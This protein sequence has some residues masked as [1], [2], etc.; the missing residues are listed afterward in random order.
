M[1]LPSGT[2]PAA[3]L[4]FL[5]NQLPLFLRDRLGV[6]LLMVAG[7]PGRSDFRLS[8]DDSVRRPRNLRTEAGRLLEG[9]VGDMTLAASL[10]RLWCSC[11]SAVES[12]ESLP[13]GEP[14]TG[15]KAG[16]LGVGCDDSGP[17]P[18]VGGRGVSGGLSSGAG[19]WV[20][21]VREKLTGVSVKGLYENLPGAMAGSDCS[22]GL[23]RAR[24]DGML[25]GLDRWVGDWPYSTGAV[26]RGWLYVGRGKRRRG[27]AQEV[28]RQGCFH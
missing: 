18:G 17:L 21:S 15:G 3:K 19:I 16:D 5:P 25:W 24:G 13:T 4:F 23:C 2:D 11:A 20:P 26:N 7:D 12:S 1:P 27:Q 22:G 14:S 8:D 28:W 10:A 9:L 6:W